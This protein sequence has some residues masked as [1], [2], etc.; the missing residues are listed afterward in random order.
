MTAACRRVFLHRT[1]ARVFDEDPDD[2]VVICADCDCRELGLI[3]SFKEELEL[4][5]IAVWDV[6]RYPF[7]ETA[8]PGNVLYRPHAGWPPSLD[9]IEFRLGRTVE[10]K[11]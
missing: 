6:D 2:L 4:E 10:V 5:V 3:S 1:Y 8:P 7:D 11:A 9:E